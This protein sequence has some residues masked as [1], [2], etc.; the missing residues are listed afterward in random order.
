MTTTLD[1][2][3]QLGETVERDGLAIT[4]LFPRRDPVCDYVSLD[5]ALA[6]GLQIGEVDEAGD[7]GE[8]RVRNPLGR[9]ALLYDGEELIGAKQNR[10]L[11]L[12]V[13]LGAG[14][15]ISVPVSCVE[16]GRWSMQGK[17]F[18]SAGHVSGPELRRR[19]AQALR[20]GALARGAAQADVWATVDHQL[21]V[22]QVA[23]RTAA[24]ADGFK[25]RA[26]EIRRAVDDF[27]M[28]PGQSGVIAALAG[29]GWSVDLISRPDVFG[30]VY[31]KLLAGYV[32][33]LLTAKGALVDPADVLA[34]VGAAVARRSGSAGLGDDLRV[35]GN[36]VIGSGLAVSGEL[37]QLSAYGVAK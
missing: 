36:G 11:N 30:Q 21:S 25:A 26:P 22:R 18:R 19:K 5:E 3:F 7:V 1:L 24:N 8:L 33:D 27:P 10:I 2:P 34:A 32:F 13:L 9:A 31:S 12:T 23:S 29:H 6:G 14:S 35:E 20:S 16:R 28:Q 4:P 15:M 17:Q 37:I